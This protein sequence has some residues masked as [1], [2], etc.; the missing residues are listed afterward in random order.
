M[1]KILFLGGNIIGVRCLQLI[2]E[3]NELDVVGVLPR[4]GDDSTIVDPKSFRFSLRKFA[5]DNK[6]LV[7]DHRSANEPDFIRR[8]RSLGAD[9]LVSIQYDKILKKEI[10][11]VPEIGCLNIHFA[12]LPKYRGCMPIPWAIIDGSSYG[13]TFHWIDEGIDTGPIID[14]VEYPVTEADTAYSLYMRATE[15]GIEIFKKN[16]PKIIDS[17]LP[18]IIQSEAESIYHPKGDPYER[19][20]SWSWTSEQIDRFV[21]AFTFPPYPSARTMYEGREVEI[22]HPIQLLSDNTN[23]ASGTIISVSNNYIDIRTTDGKIRVTKIKFSDTDH[24]LIEDFNLHLEAN[25][26]FGE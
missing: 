26:K 17:S 11:G 14:K 21:R 22:I 19:W 18:R 24:P 7:F 13:V 1:K 10:I 20:I 8:A 15:E 4:A 16:I 23:A 2:L 9:Y 25:K 5:T 6:L 12:P 3:E